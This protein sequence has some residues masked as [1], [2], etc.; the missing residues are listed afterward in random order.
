MKI[1]VKL[2]LK[3]GL[4]FIDID[5]F[6]DINDTL[7]HKTGDEVLKNVARLLNLAVRDEDV[8]ARFG[9]D[10]FLIL[11]PGLSCE[12]DVKIISTRILNSP[13]RCM[14]IDESELYLS[15]SLGASFFPKSGQTIDELITTADEAMY[16][17][18]KNG[19]NFCYLHNITELGYDKIRIKDRIGDCTKM[20][21]ET[22]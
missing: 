21:S 4:I 17:S 11:L 16:I 10:E 1:N 18:K 3:I 8:V 5:K 2:I 12:E 13:Y 19:G 20:G 7:G 9:G 22:N 14:L 15:F 6:K